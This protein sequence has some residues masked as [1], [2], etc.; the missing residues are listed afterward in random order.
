MDDK[1]KLWTTSDLAEAAGL[2]QNRLRQ[3]LQTVK[4]E[5]FKVGR[6]WAVTDAEARRWLSE[7]G[8]DVNVDTSDND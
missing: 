8:I 3:I 1:P 4:L 6:D 7:R 2:S 5:G